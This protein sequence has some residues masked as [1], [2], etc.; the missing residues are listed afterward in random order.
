MLGGPFTPYYAHSKAVHL[1]HIMP[2]QRR[3]IYAILCPFKGGTFTPYYAH[4]KAVHLRHIMPIQRRYI[5]AILCTFKG[6]PFT[7]YYAHS[8]SCSP[9]HSVCRLDSQCSGPWEEEETAC[10]EQQNFKESP[11]DFNIPIGSWPEA[12]K[13]PAHGALKPLEMLK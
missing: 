7:P 11:P 13:L 8:N 9:Q 4:S 12:S 1:R 5:Y 6:G 10:L 3:Y 2:I